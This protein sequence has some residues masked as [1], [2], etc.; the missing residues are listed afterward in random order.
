MKT[1]FGFFVSTKELFLFLVA[2]LS[3]VSVIAQPL[4][5]NDNC[6]S[7]IA[8]PVNAVGI[9]CTSTVT[10][11]LN[12]ATQSPPGIPSSCATGNLFDVW[13]S[14]TATSTSH[15]IRLDNYG[16]NYTRRQFII[17][18]GGCGV[19]G[20]SIV[21]CSALSS[22]GTAALSVSFTDFSPGTTYYIRVMY[23]T[24][25]PM[26]INTNGDFRL[27]VNTATSMTAPPVEVGK[28]YTNITRPNG[29]V[30]MNGDI[31]EFRAMIGV[32]FWGQPG[33]IYNVTFHDTIPAGLSYVNNSIRF[34]TNEGFQ[35]ES[36]ITG[37]VNLTDVPG[38]DEAVRVMNVLR[39]N[40]G[41]LVRDGGSSA[42][43]RQWVYQGYPAIS[44]ITYLSAGGGKISS[45]GRPNQFGTFVIIVV[46]YQA[47]V[48]ATT[49]TIL[50]TSSGAY[51]YKT[52]TSSID[53]ITFPQ[54]IRNFPSRQIFISSEANLCQTSVGINT[55]ANG[56]FGSGTAKH[57]STQL[58]IAPGYT[59]AP[60]TK[61]SPGDGSF[62]V[63]NNTSSG[64][65]TN[66]YG[67][68]PTSGSGADTSRVFNVWDII[69]D[70]TGAVNQ[71]SGNFATPRGTNG[72]YMAV[73]NAAYGI[74]TA[75]QR[76]ING[77]CSDTYYEFSAWF[78]NVCAGCSSDSAGRTMA[79]GTSF[80][81]YLPVKVQNDS[82]GVSP[83]LTYTIDGV[84][85]YTTGN[86]IYDKRW[87]KKGFLFKTGP[88]QTSVSL[89]IRN[90]AP[91]GG[92]NDWAIDDIGLATC[93][94]SLN[95]RPSNTPTYCLNGQINMSVIVN[96]FY[97]NYTYYQW[98]RSTDGGTTWLP[99]PEL[100]GV[101][102]Y[103]YTFNGTSYVDTV[104]YPSLIASAGMTGYKYR[105]K[106]ATSLANLSSTSCSVYNTVDVIT[107]TVNS[108]CSVLPAELLSFSAQ[109]KNGFTELR[110][111]SKQEQSLQ[112]YDVERS[113]DGKDF[114]K[115]GTV[116]ARGGTAEESYSFTDLDAVSGKVY[117]RLRLVAAANSTYKF[118]NIL[119]VAAEGD[120]GL[121]NLVNP[122]NAKI[123]FQL[124]VLQNQVADVQLM[125]ASGKPVYQKKMNVNKGSNA[126]N[127][128]TPVHLQSGNYLLRVI[129][130][131]GIVHKL[132]QKQ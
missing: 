35:Y 48:T 27:C 66:K 121:S 2:I 93:L 38:D 123:S 131:E 68:F 84:D 108:G 116:A 10:G 124:T 117:Y 118:S 56:N 83:D 29:G 40:V 51:R 99:A 96:T 102:S 125:D 43:N 49:G 22:S 8:A 77:L 17:Y 101:Q 97:N 132:I 42:A 103:T 30:I 130:Q 115:I 14:F 127:I 3:V 31:L 72:G 18:Q 57:D 12:N 111:I 92:G 114:I 37:S 39:V 76:T 105:I 80:K 58:T 69:G 59:W 52:T 4:P 95:M 26:G 100:P 74:N 106:T 7:A 33:N 128:E 88:S 15:T 71:D 61:G 54:T 16:T 46:R 70:H 110:W 28:S 75:V 6:G 44:P 73:V 85:Y 104:A 86:I 82:A 41:S 21:T 55:Y 67:P 32:G 24:S 87:I 78:K 5:A 63:V 11:T 126:L 91:G 20:L 89:T 47:Q 109:L 94:P 112:Q 120:F 23:P 62:A 50:T 45:K 34:E 64:G 98:E 13:Y 90:N 36:G 19:I 65:F 25:T 122:F 119:S 113:N 53:D 107:I 81:P 79:N 9:N 60:F 129:L 1:C